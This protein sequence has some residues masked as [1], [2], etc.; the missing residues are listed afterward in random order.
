MCRL[1]KKWYKEIKDLTTR[2][3][4]HTINDETFRE[5][6]TR[7]SLVN[8]HICF[9]DGI[10][11]ELFWIKAVLQCQAGRQ[12]NKLHLCQVC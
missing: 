4:Q 7:T 12:I 2:S 9:V 10:C 11:T 3:L 1:Q 5:S 8:Q 6:S